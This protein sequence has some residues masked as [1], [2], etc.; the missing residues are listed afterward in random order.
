MTSTSKSKYQFALFIVQKL[1]DFQKQHQFATLSLI[2][3]DL[4]SHLVNSRKELSH[5]YK[6]I[7]MSISDLTVHN[8]YNILHRK[9]TTPM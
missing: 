2:A 9:I 8:K 6:E 5:T 1:T 7:K 4:H 3:H